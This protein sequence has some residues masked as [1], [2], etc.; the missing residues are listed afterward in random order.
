[1]ESRS[2]AGASA[3]LGD[4]ASRSDDVAAFRRHANLL[5]FGVLLFDDGG[6]LLAANQPARDLL[7]VAGDLPTGPAWASGLELTDASCRPV[8]PSRLSSMLPGERDVAHRE[9]VRLE[10]ADGTARWLRAIVGPVVVLEP[11]ERM[12]V[13]C[14]LVD[15]TDEEETHRGLQRA[16]GQ[17][18]E[19]V[20][21]APDVI[22]R[23]AI[24]PDAEPVL[25]YVNPAVTRVLGY[26]PE[27]CYRNDERARAMLDPAD[28]ERLLGVG[29]LGV[30]VETLVFRM[31]RAD[32]S[33][34]WMEHRV[35]PVRDDVGAVVGLV[36]V[37]RDI[38]ALKTMEAELSHR[39]LHDP[40]T[41]LPNRALFVESL[42]R[43][44]ARLRRHPGLVALLY[45][46]LD[47]FKHVNDNLGHQVGDDV[48]VAVGRRLTAALRPSDDVARLGGDEFLAVLQD[49]AEPEEA[50]SV[51]RRVLDAVASALDIGGGAIVVTVSVGI[52]FTG[53]DDLSAQELIRRADQAMYAAKQAGRGTIVEWSAALDVDT[54]SGGPWERDG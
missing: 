24:V 36:G 9:L 6:G 12:V 18:R 44:L 8:H 1:M 35:V 25:E 47:N 33:S 34:A 38:T 28:L 42:D 52:A 49:L 54:S 20:E 31:T 11:P 17:F 4:D 32:G 40:L 2:D 21:H 29:A 48:L 26:E 23:I 41:G 30:P 5:P 43:S 53:D 50:R 16:E 45:I 46:D 51:A 37:A 7:G 39:A 15:V 3:G 10:R 14:T 27:D 22:Y 19:L 13:V